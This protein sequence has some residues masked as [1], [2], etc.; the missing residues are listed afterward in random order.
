M[1]TIAEFNIP[2]EEFA[3]RETLEQHPDITLEVERVAAHDT[4]HVTPF[5]WASGKEHSELLPTFEADP[6]VEESKLLGEYEEES[7]Y[8]MEW[9]DQTQIIG[10][11]L[12]EENATVQRA[13]T[14]D[15]QWHLHVLFPE[16]S[17]LTRTYDYA[18][19]HGFRLD[20]NQIY[21][22]DAIQRVRFH[23]TEKQYEVL[24]EA[25]ERG[26]YSIPRK[27]NQNELADALGISNQATSERMRRA[28]LSLIENALLVA[29]NEESNSHSLD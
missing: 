17:G 1:S 24:I 7:L 6:S 9:T 22:A 2:A 13:I 8:Q 18:K 28:T 15:R 14:T 27:I 10:Y 4:L 25:A 20:I 26:Y 16:R 19:E 3:L 12:L 11:M 21:D 29:E 5:I 23:L